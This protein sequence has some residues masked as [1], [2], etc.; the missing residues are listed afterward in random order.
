MNKNKSGG[1]GEGGTLMTVLNDDPH[2]LK[3]PKWERWGFVALQSLCR[4][5]PKL[6]WSLETSEAEVGSRGRG[7]GRGKTAQGGGGGG[8]GGDGGLLVRAL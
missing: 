5:R 2:V 7:S 1:R 4:K 6:D 8:G 3:V